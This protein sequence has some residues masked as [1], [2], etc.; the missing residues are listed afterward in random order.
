[1]AQLL[2]IWRIVQQSVLAAWCIRA[3]VSHASYVMR[4][5]QKPW[6]LTGLYELVAYQRGHS[7]VFYMPDQ[8]REWVQD[9][10]SVYKIDPLTGGNSAGP[11]LRAVVEELKAHDEEAQSIGANGQ[12]LV[13][14]VLH[15]D[16]MCVFPPH[17][18][19]SDPPTYPYPAMLHADAPKS[20]TAVQ[21]LPHAT[22]QRGV[23]HKASSFSHENNVP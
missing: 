22:T 20:E 14:K 16:N 18:L 13:R 4:G 6:G 19:L 12:H 15:P 10:K 8:G 1:M 2:P 17:Q 21:T 9:R 23:Q 7:Q 11:Y 3:L 5:W